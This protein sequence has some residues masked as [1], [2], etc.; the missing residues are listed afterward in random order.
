MKLN[1]TEHTLEYALKY[2]ISNTLQQIQSVDNANSNI[3]IKK[4]TQVAKVNSVTLDT[5][6]VTYNVTLQDTNDVFV[7]KEYVNQGLL[8]IPTAGSFIHV[9]WIDSTTPYISSFNET[10]IMAM[11]YEHI[12]SFQVNKILE[13]GSRVSN[14][15]VNDIST[16]IKSPQVS[17]NGDEYGPLFIAANLIQ[18]INYMK[19]QYN[20]VVEALTTWLPKANDGGAA[21]QILVKSLMIDQPINTDIADVTNDTVKHGKATT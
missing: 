10:D 5:T 16:Q 2:A 11:N 19:T 20:K 13:D 1:K 9:D 12:G 18:E 7:F 6:E 17:L 8:V 14:I 4:K 3:D 21:L 15:F